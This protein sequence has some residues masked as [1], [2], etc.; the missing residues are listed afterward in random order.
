M[1]VVIG[2]LMQVVG[3]LVG[4][5]GLILV[6]RMLLPVFKM[7]WDHPVLRT[8]VVI[9]DPILKVTNRWLGIPSYGPSHGSL[10]VSR[11][12]FVSSAVALVVLW[13]GR[14]LIEWVLRLVMLVPMWSVEPL[15][16]LG[17]ILSYLFS[18]VFDLYGL[19]LFVRVLFSW[20]RVPY[21][22]PV[23]RFLWKITEPV[24]GLIRSVMPPLP[25][26]DISPVIAFFL[27]RLLQQVVSS[28][29]SWIF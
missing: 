2:L 4:T 29:L 27:L 12:D 7:R 13:A 16:S 25:G 15:N 3:V 5:I 14:S 22:S 20:I 28:L 26:I 24:L 19:A 9:T 1:T 10:G 23:T 17:S 21:S 11:S 8:V 6:L 18:A